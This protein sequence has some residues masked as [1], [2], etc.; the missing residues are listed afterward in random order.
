MKVFYTLIIFLGIGFSSTAQ[1]VVYSKLKSF[2]KSQKPPQFEIIGKVKDNLLIYQFDKSHFIKVYDDEMNQINTVNLSFLPNDIGGLKFLNHSD[3]CYVVWEKIMN[4]TIVYEY[5]KINNNGLLVGSV[6]SLDTIRLRNLTGMDFYSKMFNFVISEDRSKIAVSKIGLS[7]D[8]LEISSKVF[9]AD[10]NILEKNTVKLANHDPNTNVFNDFLINN[11]GD[12][13]YSF[14]NNLNGQLVNYFQIF[15]KKLN[16]KK[17]YAVELPIDKIHL[18]NPTITIDNNKE[19]YLVNAY[20]VDTI[21]NK[22]QIEGFYLAKVSFNQSDEAKDI[23]YAKRIPFTKFP[24]NDTDFDLFESNIFINKDSRAF[25][26]KDGGY[27]VVT[28]NNYRDH[29]PKFTSR[30]NTFY[31][32]NYY[33]SSNN[34]VDMNTPFF[35]SFNK[36][37]LDAYLRIDVGERPVTIESSNVKSFSFNEPDV[38]LSSNGSPNYLSTPPINNNPYNRYNVSLKEGNKLIAITNINKDG[39]LQNDTIIE[40]PEMMKFK[41]QSVNFL[42]NYTSNFFTVTQAENNFNLIAFSKNL[43]NQFLL[44]RF[45]LSDKADELEMQVI[46][47]KSDH[48]F[49]DVISAKQVSEN[50]LIIPFFRSNKMGFA[51]IY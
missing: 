35:R 36:N 11:K 14:S 46:K 43:N 42:G 2:S 34:M 13:V 15:V 20:S 27:I 17:L 26:K 50:E 32:S 5:G 8:T 23:L 7:K 9:D 28:E 29:T 40:I 38:A 10:F 25:M 18:V 41:R 24:K 16:I 45:K 3:F 30:P 22:K 37:E 4:K 33:V 49:F 51:K 31:N 44:N 1:N 39:V 48:Y 47:A 12:I 6:V 21:N 19:E